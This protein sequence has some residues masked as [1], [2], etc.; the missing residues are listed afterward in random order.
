[1]AGP[2]M[3]GI[4]I[5]MSYSNTH[6]HTMHAHMHKEWPGKMIKIALLLFGVPVFGQL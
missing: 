6:T 5:D 1:M 3:R 2:S 4:G